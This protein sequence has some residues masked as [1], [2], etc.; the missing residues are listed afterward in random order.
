MVNPNGVHILE[1]VL[2]CISQSIIISKINWPL[3]DRSSKAARQ[4]WKAIITKMYQLNGTKLPVTHRLREW[5]T[6][7]S[8]RQTTYDWY[9]SINTKELYHINDNRIEKYFSIENDRLLLINLDSKE[10][11]PTLPDDAIL[12]PLEKESFNIHQE[13]TFKRMSKK[14]TNFKNGI[15]SLEEWKRKLISNHREIYSSEPLATF[16]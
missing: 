8:L 6:P 3:Q 15:K 16:I 12:V 2:K 1:Y 5:T 4:L 7:S 11:Y 14:A 10:I 13:F 9:H